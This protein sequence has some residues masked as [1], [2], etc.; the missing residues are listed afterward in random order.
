MSRHGVAGGGRATPAGGGYGSRHGAGE[1]PQTLLARKKD[2]KIRYFLGVYIFFCIF[3]KRNRETGHHPV[4]HDKEKAMT[5]TI[6]NISD[7]RRTARQFMQHIG[8]STV[9]AF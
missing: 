1:K 8:D 6:D 2:K 3:A 9:L 5:L 4:C 7:I